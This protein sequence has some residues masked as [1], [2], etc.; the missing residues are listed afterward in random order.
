MK[1][2]VILLFIISLSCLGYANSKTEATS[3]CTKPECYGLPTSSTAD[4]ITD[5]CY[6]SLPDHCRA[7]DKEYTQCYPT[8]KS[9]TTIGV[10]ST[11]SCGTGFWESI[12]STADGLWGLVTYPYNFIVDEKVRQ[13]A[14]NVTSHVM[15]F[16]SNTSLKEMSGLVGGAAKKELDEFV[17]CLNHKGKSKYTCKIAMFA[18][19]LLVGGK[20]VSAISKAKKA[21]K[22]KEAAKK[23]AMIK[24][25]EELLHNTR[26]AE[27]KVVDSG[28]DL[29]QLSVKEFG[30][31]RH[32]NDHSVG[33]INFSTLID[34]Q[35]RYLDKVSI[36]KLLRHQLEQIDL[37]KAPSIVK[38]LPD[39]AF[40]IVIMNYIRRG[41]DV[42]PA[43]LEHITFYQR[44]DIRH[45][46]KR[47]KEIQHPSDW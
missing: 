29:S 22:A 8:N 43:I 10:E 26:I 40:T 37:M 27:T 41:K 11:K 1:K 38:I 25:R 34:Q 21:K 12:K 45:M 31:L 19:E 2:S 15:H 13:E 47:S 44:L 42:P 32:F 46:L 33:K 3:V 20:G 28:G 23:K 6:A 30:Y 17:N 36:S 7:V 24:A 14:K 39:P 9:V 35:V 4:Q 16:V 5:I 18:L